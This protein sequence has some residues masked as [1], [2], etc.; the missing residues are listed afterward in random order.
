MKSISWKERAELVGITAIVASLIFVG[1]QLQQEHRIAWIE[2]GF[3]LTESYYEQRN[4][5]IENAAIWAKGNAGVEEL[6][7]TEVVIYKALI[8]K[9]WAH[10]YW[11]S[12][13]MKQLGIEL[14]VEVHDFA[15]FLHRN[16]GARRTWENW[17]AIEQ[18]YRSKLIPVP[19]GVEMMNIVFADLEELNQ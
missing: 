9:E 8:R 16:P 19:V 13:A 4:G 3:S 7:S 12:N 14:S 18:E 2:A 17:M 5:L 1:L 11:S 6:S 15:G 10:A